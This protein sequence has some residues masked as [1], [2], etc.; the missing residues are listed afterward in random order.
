MKGL[1]SSCIILFNRILRMLE[2]LLPVPMLLA[3]C[4][5]LAWFL[6]LFGVS[7][8]K[9]LI[10]SYRSYF[11]KLLPVFSARLAEDKW[12]DRCEVHMSDEY[13]AD[14]AAGKKVVFVFL[15]EGSYRLLPYWLRAIGIRASVIIKCKAARRKKHRRWRDQRDLF[16]EQKTVWGRDE[17]K[18]FLNVLDQG[19]SLLLAIDVDIG[20]VET[21]TLSDGREA[22]IPSGAFRV[23]EKHSCVLY[24][25]GLVSKGFW[26]FRLQIG[27]RYTGDKA[28]LMDNLFETCEVTDL[29]ELSFLRVK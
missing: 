23:A 29:N 20:N 26:K 12:L 5:P 4:I 25:C 24:P 7:R 16:P 9:T 13:S 14:V 22:I 11:H 2:R 28:K 10:Q 1:K 8:K 17:L 18:R 3:V 27:N 21:I 6:A 15:H 19:G